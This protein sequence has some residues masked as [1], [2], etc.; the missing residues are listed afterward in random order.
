MILSTLIGYKFY[1]VFI[2]CTTTL[3]FAGY[4]LSLEEKAKV[5]GND[6]VVKFEKKI[7]ATESDEKNRPTHVEFADK[8]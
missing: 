6:S 8:V 5:F 1:P 7:E 4:F 3:W 2:F